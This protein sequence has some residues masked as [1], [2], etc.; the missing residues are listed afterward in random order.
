MTQVKEICYKEFGKCIEISNDVAK[1]YITMEVG[2][3]IINYSTKNGENM[4]FEDNKQTTTQSGEHFDAYYGKGSKWHIYGGHRLWTSPEAMPRSYYPDNEPYKY[5]EIENGVRL[6][7]NEQIRNMYQYTIEVTMSSHSSDVCVVHKITNTGAFEAEF[8]AWALSVTDKGG[9]AVVPM[10]TRETGL[11]ANRVVAL[12]PYSKMTDK[13]AF[14]GDKFITLSQDSDTTCPFKLG[15]N[16]EDGYVCVF[17]HDCLFVKQFDYFEGKKYPDGGMSVEM[18][19][20][21]NFL[22]AETLS[23]MYKVAPGETIEHVERWSLY[24]NVERPAANDE[25][26]LAKIMDKYVK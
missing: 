15:I 12:W 25:E 24:D 13:R 7:C 16:G 2:P 22:E 5:E 4:M 8:A 20:C 26:T 6:I 9:M 14:F 10:P 19:T 21:E 1:V 3:R 23:P 11:L 17:N 18:Y